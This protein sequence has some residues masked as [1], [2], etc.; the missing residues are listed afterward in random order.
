MKISKTGLMSLIEKHN[1][2]RALIVVGLVAVAGL[3]LFFVSNA[4]SPNVFIEPENGTLTGACISQDQ[5]AAGGSSIKFGGGCSLDA[6]FRGDS[7]LVEDTRFTVDRPDAFRDGN[8]IGG[9]SETATVFY[10]NQYMMF[11]RTFVRPDG[12]KQTNGVP[13]GIAL[14]TSVD[15]H[16]WV[17]H[18]EGRPVIANRPSRLQ[19]GGG[20]TPAPCELSIYAPSAIV[21]SDDSLKIVYETMDT[22][23]NQPAGIPRHWI[24]AASSLD[25]INWQAVNDSSGAPAKILVANTAWEGYDAGARVFRANVGTPALTKEGNTYHL[26]YHGHHCCLGQSNRGLASGGSLTSLARSSANPSLKPGAGWQAFG[27][28][29]GDIIKEGSYY[30]YIYEAWKGSDSCG[31]NDTIV[32]WGLARSTDKVNWAYSAANPIRTDRIKA[33]CGEDMPSWQ[34]VNGEAP[35]VVTTNVDYPLPSQAS[36]RRYKIVSVKTAISN[37]D[38]VGVGMSNSDEGYWQVARDGGVFTFGNAAF[39]GSA[40]NSGRTDIVGMAVRPGGDGYWVAAANG[41][42]YAFGAAA[43]RGDMAGQPLNGPVVGIERDPDGDG[44]WLVAADGGVFAFGAPNHGSAGNIRLNQ[45]IVGMSAAS[46]GNGYW[47]VARDGGIFAF[48]AA[49]NHGSLPGLGIARTDIIGMSLRPD[50]QGYWLVSADG[51][52]YSFGAQF[53][54]GTDGFAP[55]AN[56]QVAAIGRRATGQGAGT[57]YYLMAKDGAIIDLGGAVYHGHA[58]GPGWNN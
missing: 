51:A 40:A 9:H 36:V 41:A 48:G 29:K 38:V 56:M 10:K 13:A 23:V 24:E 17:V 28:G 42:V 55:F 5:T 3:I 21:D 30:Y 58:R 16:S 26:Y 45:P 43:H 31:R 11:Y 19:A 4:A 14:T 34:V 12:S 7:Q 53:Y 27:P 25:G 57:G 52:V 39:H 46:D 1:R 20:C 2:L 18:N 50:N 47:L 35:M 15:G 54:G 32:G 8:G 49:Q 37:A 33:S 6:L 22:G 44:Y